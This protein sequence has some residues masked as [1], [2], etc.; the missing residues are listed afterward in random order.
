MSPGVKASLSWKAVRMGPPLAPLVHFC[1][2]VAS[3]SAPGV[4]VSSSPAMLTKAALTHIDDSTSEFTLVSVN[5]GRHYNLV[6]YSVGQF[7]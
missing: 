7:V 2:P 4:C 1:T 3:N 6:Q 5:L